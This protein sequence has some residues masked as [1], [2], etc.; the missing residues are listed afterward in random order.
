MITI[1]IRRFHA[2]R[3]PSEVVQEWAVEEGQTL[4]EALT[5]IKTQKDPTLT[6]RSGCRSCVCGSCAVRVNG[7]EVLACAYKPKEGDLV[8]PLRFAPVI[9]DLVTDQNG[10]FDTLRRVKAWL[11]APV[12]D[13]VVTP[14]EE[15]RT[16][17]QSDCILCHSCYSACPVF[18]TLPLFAG[19][20][21]LTRAWRYVADP[22][23]GDAK[24]KI[25]AIQQNGVW[26]CTLC[27]ECTAVCPQGIDPKSDILMLR[28]KST[29]MG[30]MDPTMG[31]FGSFGLDF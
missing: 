15:K 27:G 4:L 8:E 5:F 12:A 13:A 14:E 25:D 22:R 29:Q 26:D 9:K 28:T 1:R 2:A 6:F 18:E 16:E 23:E 20:F 17:V 11:E 3:K 10:G 30:H 24:S 21:A 7:R 31:S 19:P